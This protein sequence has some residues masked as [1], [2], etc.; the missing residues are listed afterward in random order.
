MPGFVCELGVGRDRKNLGTELLE[1]GVI[2]LH[3]FEF[4]RADECEISRVEED[5]GP[6][7]TEIREVCLVE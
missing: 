4:G 1:L 2:L 7:A 6:L 3:L 5:D